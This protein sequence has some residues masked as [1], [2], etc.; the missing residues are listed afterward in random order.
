MTPYEATF[1]KKPNLS[2]VREWGERVWVRVE[3]GNKLGKRVR[4]GRWMGVDEQSKG[5]HIY[6]PDT[7]TVGVECNIY[8]DKTGAS[9]SRL[10]GEE[11]DGFIK[12]KPDAPF[13]SKN[14]PNTSTEPDPIPTDP[15]VDQDDQISSET[16]EMPLEP[17]SRPKRSRKPTERVRDLMSG[18]AV[19][20]Y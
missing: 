9:A 3:G 5:I 15:Q 8:V 10:E 19:S 12:T 2:E 1:G 17:D 13:I 4:E 20:D 7:R 6:W 18:K 14:P 11:W 16:D